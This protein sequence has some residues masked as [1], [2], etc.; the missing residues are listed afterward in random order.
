MPNPAA[1]YC[2]E[3]GGELVPMEDEE[4]NQYS[5]C[6]LAD[7]TEVEEW[8]YYRAN[9]PVTELS[10]EDLAAAETAIR[11]V[12]ENEWEVK[13]ESL[14][15]TYAGDEISNANLEYCQSLN[16]EATKC[17]VF[18]S[19][20]HIPEQDVVMA[21]AFEPNADITGWGWTLGKNAAWEWEVLS[22]GFG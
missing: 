2:V 6:R 4:W 19:S 3:Q 15:V 13:V 10:A 8:E 22:N 9:N 14:E 16:A 18:T 12:V 21:W 11:N 17:A 5:I 1:V 7:G 20:F